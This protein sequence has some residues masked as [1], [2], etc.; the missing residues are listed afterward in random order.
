[1]KLNPL[2]IAGIVLVL[3]LAPGVVKWWKRI[4][5]ESTISKRVD[6]TRHSLPH[7]TQERIVQTGIKLE[8]HLL[9][10]HFETTYPFDAGPEQT[11][12]MTKAVKESVCESEDYRDML[13]HG[14]TIEHTFE[15]AIELGA[16]HGTGP[17]TVTMT[18]A[19]CPAVVVKK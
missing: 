11:V 7:V 9:K 5:Y 10:S 12:A 18:A 2:K 17:L 3:A 6:A 8:G 13:G 15:R 16:L 19:D 14:Y 1:M 4:S